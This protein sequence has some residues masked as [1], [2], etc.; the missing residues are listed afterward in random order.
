MADKLPVSVTVLLPTR[1]EEE[2]LGMTV[3]SIP[4]DWCDELEIMIVDGN[5]TDRTR[6]IA[7]EMGVRVHLEPRKG[8]G[9]AYRTGFDVAKGD[10]IVTMDADCTYPA[11]V[12]PDLVKKLLDDELDFITCDRLT[13][14]EE[15]SMSGLHGFGNWMLSFNARLAFGYGIKDSQSGMWVFRK[16]IFENPKMRPTNDGMPLSEEMKIL[17]RKV[18]GHDKAIEISVPYRPRVG[19]AEIHTW[20]D[21]WKNLRFIWAK[22]FG[23]HRTRTEWGAL[24]DNPDSLNGD[25]PEQKK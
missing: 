13:L 11:E 15:G 25:L 19:E 12:V 18:L 21:G 14:A 24:P 5:S 10:I 4:R 17:A 1:N 22:R 9:R 6:E 23:L 2:A 7:L 8:Y 3:D 20:G 16:S